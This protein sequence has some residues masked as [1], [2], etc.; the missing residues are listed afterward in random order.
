MTNDCLRVVAV[1]FSMLTVI[2][3]IAAETFPVK[4]V[5]FLIAYPAGGTSD[6]L[7][8]TIAHEFTTAWQ[9]QTLVDNRPGA[10][11]IIATQTLA[12][13]VPDGHTIMLIEPSFAINPSLHTKLPYDP[14][15]SFTPVGL[16][17][18]VQNV[19]VATPALPA[20]SLPELITLAR[21]H[22]GKLNYGGSGLGASVF[23]ME[24]LKQR[25]NINVVLIRYKGAP[26][27]TPDLISGQ[28]Q[29]TLNSLPGLLPYIL[30][31]QIQ[32]I[33]IVSA[34]RAPA[35]PDVATAAESGYA[36]LDVDTWYGIIAPARVP[37]NA[38][39]R[40]NDELGRMMGVPRV[41][42]R[43]SAAGFELKTGGPEQFGELIRSDIA[44]WAKVVKSSGIK[45]E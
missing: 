36:G 5:R 14:V 34:T 13:A 22:P 7:A 25:A 42:E 40:M 18:V 38:I 45:L 32:P 23:G 12:N 10:D 43:L 19:L 39:R 2:P 26:A 27:L 28:I 15:S 11:G 30:N 44:K 41:K 33:A 4:P 29:L 20:K 35:L 37:Q 31:K 1:F 9:Q 21:A 17:A 24:I 8:R 6:L 3:A 16:A